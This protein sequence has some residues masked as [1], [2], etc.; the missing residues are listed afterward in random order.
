MKRLSPITVIYLAFCIVWLPTIA[1]VLDD[2]PQGWE[3]AV[4]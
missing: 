3:V 2:T 1:L 4:M